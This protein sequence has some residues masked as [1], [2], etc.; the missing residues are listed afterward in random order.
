MLDMLLWLQPVGNVIG[1][2]DFAITELFCL[3]RASTASRNL[4]IR[5]PGSTRPWQHVLEPLVAYL[6][7]LQHLYCDSSDVT[8]YSLNIGP[9]FYP[10]VAFSN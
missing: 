9:L 5:N 6:I 7:Y 4:L 3:I 1:G 8:P 2:G 10:T